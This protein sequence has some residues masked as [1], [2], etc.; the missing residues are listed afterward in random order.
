MLVTTLGN[1]WN[2]IVRFD[3]GD[4]IRLHSGPCACGRNTGLVAEAVEGRVSNL[5]FT[6]GGDLVTTMA[7]DKALARVDGL[8]DYRW[9]SMARPGM[10]CSW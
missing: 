8:R 2:S 1:P 3:T 4:L 10:S 5:T 9:S 6:T 7:L